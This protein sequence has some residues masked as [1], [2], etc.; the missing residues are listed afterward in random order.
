[1]NSKGFTLLELIATVIILSLI[2]LIAVP[3]VT[4]FTEMINIRQRENDIE[5][6][7]IAAAKYAYDTNKNLI[8]VDELVK[9]GYILGDED[10]NIVDKVNK[11]R[12]NCYVVE[13]EKTKDYYNAKFIDD[14][15]YDNNGVCDENK[16]NEMNEEISIEVI[17]NG[18]V[19]EY[20]NEWLNGSV[21][22]RVYSNTVNINCITNRCLW[23][24]QSGVSK[25]GV[26][27]IEVANINGLLETRYNFQMTEFTSD[28]AVKRYNSSIN[29]KIDNE[30][31]VIYENE[32]KVSNRFVNSATKKVVIEASDGKGSG[33]M[34]YYLGLIDGNTCQ[35]E[36][37]SYQES[38]TFT[39]SQNGTYLI[40]VKDNA[41]NISSYN[42]LK[43]S[44]IK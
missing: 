11:G 22:L 27:E 24:S 13:M 38:N 26:S 39:V 9:E 17:N 5:N 34:G 7:E 14:K 41:G 21:N 15:N 25:T 40:C 20:H 16:L 23:T 28:E 36:N 6:I 44:Y 30:S 8:F 19:K 29:L 35:N 42:S 32:I 2:M 18:E 12:L 43:I 1:M 33:I 37:I 10:G 4:N 3:S 31:P